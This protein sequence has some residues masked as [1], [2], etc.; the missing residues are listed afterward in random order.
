M[1]FERLLD[2]VL[3]APTRKQQGDRFERF[4]MWVLLNAPRYKG[5]FSNV[6]LW[7]DSPERDGADIGVDIIAELADGSGRWAV[8][9]KGY[10]DLTRITKAHIDSFLAASPS[11]RYAYRLVVASTDLLSPNARRTIDLQNAGTLLKSDLLDLPIEWP[12]RLEELEGLNGADAISTI[13]PWPHQ[14]RAVEEAAIALGVES[15]GQ[16]IMPCGTGKTFVSLWLAERLKAKRVLF[17]APSLSLVGRTLEDWAAHAREPFRWIAVCSD[18]TVSDD[19]SA[20]ANDLDSREIV[21]DLGVKVTTEPGEIA[22]FLSGSGPRVVFATYQSSARIAEAMSEEDIAGFDIAICDEAHRLAG[23]TNRRYGSILSNERIPTCLRVFMTA[24]PRTYS[25]R[26]KKKALE[27]DVLVASMDDESVF[28]PVLHELSFATAIEEDLLA[29][30]RVIILG[31]LDEDYGRLFGGDRRLRVDDDEFEVDPRML[32]ATIAFAK[33][34]R[35]YALKRTISFHRSVARAKTFQAV[36]TTLFHRLQPGERPPGNLE[37]RHLNGTMSTGQRKDVLGLL[38][39]LRHADRMLVTN[40]RCLGEGVDVK[41][42]D[43]IVFADPRRSRIEVVQAVGRA[44]RRSDDKVGTII[45]P[46]SVQP[47]E[48]AGEILRSSEFDAVWQV[49]SALRSHDERLGEEIDA[50]AVSRSRGG[51]GALPPRIVLDL[52]GTRVDLRDLQRAFA[53]RTVDLLADTGLA[54]CRAYAQEFGSIASVKRGLVYRG[55]RLG[56]WLNRRRADRKRGALAADQIAELDELGMVWDPREQQWQEGLAL[57]RAYVQEFGSLALVRQA[58]EYREFRLGGWL[59]TR[60]LEYRQGRLSPDR[61]A[62]LER[63][64]IVWDPRDKLWQEGLAACRSYAAEHGSINSV[65]ARLTH[66]GFQLGTWLDGRRSDFQQ[67]RLSPD[68]I[69]ALEELGIVWDAKEQSWEDGLA[70]CRAYS[71]EFGSLAWVKNR[72]VYRDFPL[73]TWLA[74][75]RSDRNAG[76]LVPERIAALEELGM[77]WN[78]HDAKWQERLAACR[79]YADEFGSLASVTNSLV[80]RDIRL[81]IWLE[82]RRG[83][84][85]RGTLSAERIAALDELGMVWDSFE[86][87]WQEGLAACRAYSEEFGSLASTKAKLVY[88]GFRLGVWLD[89]RRG[90]R[91]RGAL[92]PKRIA[93]LD[94]LGM[95]WDPRDRQWQEGLA[96]CRAYAKEFGSLLPPGSLVYRGYNLGE[97]VERQRARR[98]RGVLSPERIA[99]LD[100]LGMTWE[101]RD[102]QW[103]EGLIICRRYAEEFGSLASANTATV[104]EGFRLGAWL[105]KRRSDRHRG[106]L[107]PDRISALDELGIVWKLPMGPRPKRRE[108]TAPAAP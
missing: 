84:R 58:D 29:D 71:D 33:A 107:A 11:N 44:I 91:K 75:R 10:R 81:G 68:R 56:F 108:A 16:V 102:A 4:V 7:D 88:R 87:L 98:R 104:Y 89:G 51:V 14:L 69:A 55:F 41:S 43:S 65:N 92:S 95:V 90:E 82:N 37:V 39:R 25:P 103:L 60:R 40:A 96:A 85:K 35:D 70:I 34:S 80:Y 101:P 26:L 49:L 45:L 99:E 23:V 100:E 54:T 67:G 17:L 93:A 38:G 73:G 59:D 12:D 47:S 1:S 28:G 30:Y 27:A 74:N 31:V 5:L 61:I 9:A 48:D 106:R 76:T 83:E 8:Q 21:S 105:S 18:Q 72:L 94:E 2:D 64:G 13:S 77:I 57:C 42:L 53:V 66:N 52:P 22:A 46:V 24:T 63:L 19:T 97:F 15:R 50:L 3:T 78:R 32:A 86:H 79:A 62:V 20:H 6:W 36:V